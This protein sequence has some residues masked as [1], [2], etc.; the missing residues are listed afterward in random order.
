MQVL[1]GGGRAAGPPAGGSLRSAVVI[2]EIALSF[3]LL[4]GS[5]L[6]FRSFLAL[7]RIDPGYDSRGVLTFF[8]SRD[9]PLPRQQGRTALLREIQSRLR[10]LPGVQSVAA[11]LRF[12]LA[13]GPGPIP[14]SVEQ[15]ASGRAEP[16][17]ADIQLVLPG[18]FETLRTPL[19]AGR[20]FTEDDNAPGRNVA[21]IDSFLAAKAFPNESAIGKR[22][23]VPFPEMPWVEVI[24]VAAHQRQVSLADPGREQIYFTDGSNGIGVSRYWAIRAAGDPAKLAGAVRAEIAAV[25]RQIAITKMQPMD[26]LVGREQ[27]GTRFSL[28][29]IGTF[30][31]IAALLASVGLYGVLASV[32][33]QRTAEIGVRMALGAAPASIFRLVAG[34]GLRLAAVGIAIGL[35][36]ALGL[37]RVMTSMLVG[38]KAT[39]PS[40]FGAMALLFF[41]IAAIASW[42]PAQRA[43]ALDPCAALRED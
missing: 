10:A 15:A 14:W 17:A 27:A 6:M 12:P 40:T 26:A 22:L 13:S 31:A 36:A 39:D 1:H 7:R 9:W 35:L 18:Y 23:F 38:V 3:V 33:R 8:L 25:D 4:I 42:R 32:V 37:T 2:A 20:T 11:S 16:H 41:V 24:G 5:G 30:A 28:V 34:Y 43:A 21:V 19:L 29:L